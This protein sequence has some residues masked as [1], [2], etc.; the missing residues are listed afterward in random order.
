MITMDMIG[1]IRRL[2]FRQHK[3]VR[4]IARST[5][6]SR[7][8][9]RTWLRQSGDEVPQ[10]AARRTQPSIKLEPYVEWLQQA[11]AINAR[12]P[13]ARR[14]TAK[15]LHAE[16]QRQGYDGA[17]SRITDVLRGWRQEDG[18]ADL[19]AFVPLTFEL[20]E[21]FQF[22][23]SEEGMVVGG[24][25]DKVQVAHLKLCA[26]RAFWLVAYPSQGHE[27][28]FDVHTRSFHALG[29]VPR[30]GIYDPEFSQ[31]TVAEMLEHEQPQLMPMPTPFDGYVDRSTV[32]RRAHCGLGTSLPVAVSRS[33]SGVLE[34]P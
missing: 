32:W 28:L 15:A 27:M 1:K 2:H 3:S 19:H 21:A 34:L 8:T 13:K 23:W 26:S 11:V 18:T 31:F 5:G 16:L 22:D 12:R 30:R 9:V 24:V 17:Y 33:H 29:G 25:H 10:Y 20:G 7:N 6:V 4:E 14:R